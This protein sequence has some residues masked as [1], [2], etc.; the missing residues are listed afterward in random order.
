MKKNIILIL[1]II[2][3]SLSNFNNSSEAENENY[4]TE[5][6]NRLIKSLG[7]SE[8]FITKI[9]VCKSGCNYSKVEDGF[10]AAISSAHKI[11][12]HGYIRLMIADGTYIETN[13]LYTND[14]AGAA[15][16]IIGNTIDNSKV[17][18]NFTNV[19]GNNYNGFSASNGGIIGLIDGVTL[20]AIGAQSNHTLISTSWYPQSYGSGI[21]AANGSVIRLGKHITINHFYYSITAD[22]G[23]VIE[24]RQ[25]GVTGTDAGD[26]NFMAR[27]N[28]VIVCV[29]CHADRAVDMTDPSQAILGECY[30][31]ERGG[32]LYIDGSTCTNPNV[33]G[34]IALSG[35]H[36]WAHGVNVSLPLRP[37]NST[38]LLATENGMIEAQ[39]STLTGMANG[40]YAQTAGTIE[41][42]RCNI[43]G[44]YNDNVVADGG[45]VMGTAT[46]SRG[47][48]T[49]YGYHAFH[50]GRMHLFGVV[51]L[52]SGNRLGNFSVEAAG[53]ANGA[54]FTASSI[55]TN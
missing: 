20:N 34:V 35:G 40:V 51:S 8:E 45:E 10:A 16:Q 37:H 50:Q 46:M 15:V 30:D 49:G 44:S 22:D 13:Q 21:Q 52:T 5:K 48:Q 28:G 18:L 4:T 42:D 43:Q 53:I 11:L 27:G 54:T 9:N 26:V 29:S 23:G 7:F 55:S 36:A 31:A 12:G 24:A 2:I 47:S 33:T 25:G 19:K 6:S 14:P 17:V 39:D 41:C 32:A 1:F 3:I 38:G